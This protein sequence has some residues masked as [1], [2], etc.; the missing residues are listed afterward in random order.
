MDYYTSIIPLPLAEKLDE[1]G[2]PIWWARVDE[3]LIP[4]AKYAE[5]FDWLM[6]NQITISIRS[7][8][9]KKSPSYYIREWCYYINDRDTIEITN[10]GFEFFCTWH[11]AAEAAIEKALTLI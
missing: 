5:V 1:K 9:H 3:G 7:L 4:S 8:I 6:E 10:E 11:E 2:V